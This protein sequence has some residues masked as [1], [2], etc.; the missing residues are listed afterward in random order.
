VGIPGSPTETTKGKSIC[1]RCHRKEFLPLEVYENL[2][3]ELLKLRPQNPGVPGLLTTLAVIL[4][5]QGIRFKP[6][7]TLKLAAK[8]IKDIE[9]VHP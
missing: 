7:A 8:L 3:S 5:N 1:P 9:G 4:R 2:R 6:F